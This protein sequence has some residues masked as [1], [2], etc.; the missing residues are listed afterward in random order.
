MSK[1][2]SVSTM[3]KTFN[4]NLL[5]CC[6]LRADFC[7]FQSPSPFFYFTCDLMVLSRKEYSGSDSYRCLCPL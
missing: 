4:S 1:Y 7:D 2:K 3:G 6:N 5:H